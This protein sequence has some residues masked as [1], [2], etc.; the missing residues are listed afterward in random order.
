[1]VSQGKI[2]ISFWL[3]VKRDEHFFPSLCLHHKTEVGI[4]M[5]G[6]LLLKSISQQ[7][8]KF[9]V[10]SYY[11]IRSAPRRKTVWTLFLHRHKAGQSTDPNTFAFWCTFFFWVPPFF[12][13][14]KAKPE[15]VWKAQAEVCWYGY[16]FV[17]FCIFVLYCFLKGSILKFLNPDYFCALKFT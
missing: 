5:R 7:R 14:H 4:T 2:L 13:R 12:T 8:L 1:M 10:L 11:T 6:L 17:L 16:D 15:M 9:K 3:S